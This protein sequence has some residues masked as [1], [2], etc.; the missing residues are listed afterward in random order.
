MFLIVKQGTH[1]CSASSVGAFLGADGC[2]GGV[3]SDDPVG[4]R[5]GARIRVKKRSACKKQKPSA[6]KPQQFSCIHIYVYISC[7]L[8]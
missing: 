6:F 7:S 2:A 8:V 3:E 5:S 1:V 4:E